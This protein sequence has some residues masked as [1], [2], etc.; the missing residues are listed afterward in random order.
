MV[1]IL[2]LSLLL[3]VFALIFKV[4]EQSNS[5]KFL[6]FLH[7]VL[8][9]F[10][11]NKIVYIISKF[12]YSLTH[13]FFASPYAKKVTIISAFGLPIGQAFRIFILING[14]IIP[15]AN[16]LL[17]LLSI[18]SVFRS[19]IAFGRVLTGN[20]IWHDLLKQSK[21]VVPLIA[22]PPVF[23]NNNYNDDNSSNK[24]NNNDSEKHTE[25]QKKKN[26]AFWLKLGAIGSFTGA[27]VGVGTL[28]VSLD[29]SNTLEEKRKQLQKEQEKLNSERIQLMEKELA[30][31]KMRADNETIRANKWKQR[32][33]DTAKLVSDFKKPT[34]A[35]KKK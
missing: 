23:Q 8:D 24:N 13:R 7:K 4:L 28:Y 16:F 9:A 2:R 30:F 26:E 21:R 11:R 25:D 29:N 5:Q 20:L 22:N 1:L 34:E 35:D 17:F 18:N 15:Y 6:R 33:R 3:G 32:E 27:V 14:P 31:E 19:M 10:T 12:C